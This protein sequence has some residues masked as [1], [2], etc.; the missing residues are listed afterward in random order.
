MNEVWNSLYPLFP[1]YN[2]KMSVQT[3]NKNINMY[4][5]IDEPTIE[6]SFIYSKYL[7]V[8]FKQQH[9][10]YFRIPFGPKNFNF[11]YNNRTLAYPE[12]LNIPKN[13]IDTLACII[14]KILYR[15]YSKTNKIKE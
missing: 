8:S 4:L 15:I 6:S 14:D 5:K 10:N 3:L 12:Q 1:N 13:N 2:K 9:K 7:H 11:K